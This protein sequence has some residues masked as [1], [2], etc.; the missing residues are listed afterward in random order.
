MLMQTISFLLKLKPFLAWLYAAALACLCGKLLWGMVTQ[1]CTALRL[2]LFVVFIGMIVGL[3]RQSRT[4]LKLLAALSL[5]AAIGLP[6]VIFNPFAA[7]DGASLPA[8]L[9]LLW[10]I[11][12]EIL[13]LLSAYV[14]DWSGASRGDSTGK[15]DATRWRAK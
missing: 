13:L 4:V 1:E 9:V 6:M 10:L 15:P 14:F 7:L 8:S 5:L 2:I 3:G 12:L 11:P